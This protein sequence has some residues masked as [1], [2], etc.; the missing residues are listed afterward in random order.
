[1]SGIPEERLREEIEDVVKTWKWRMG[2]GQV[3]MPTET[4]IDEIETAIWK[5][6]SEALLTEAAPPIPKVYRCGC[7]AIVSEHGRM[8]DACYVA[9]N[10]CD[11]TT[12]NYQGG[13][14][15]GAEE[16]GERE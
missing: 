1:M 14:P 15:D 7:G 12:V 9:F 4:A 10:K 11:S 16:R 8:C 6:G 5:V 3:E 2:R 13:K